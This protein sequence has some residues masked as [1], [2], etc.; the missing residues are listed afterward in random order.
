M[1]ALPRIAPQATVPTLPTIKTSNY[2]VY[3]PRLPSAPDIPKKINPLQPSPP[4]RRTVAWETID[5]H[6]LNEQRV[7]RMKQREHYRYHNS[8]SKYY[9]GSIP[10]KEQY[11][12]STRSVLKQ[13][14]TDLW[15]QNRQQI[16]DKV[17][18]S[19]QAVAYDNS[20]RMQDAVDYQNKFSYLKNFRDDNKNLMESAWQRRR[21]SKFEEDKFDREQLRYNPI[22]WSATL[23]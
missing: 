18:E 14:M 12:A 22:N 3:P 21:Q 16:T 2:E 8:W 23:K 10:E 6:Y 17:Q 20:C 11:R 13:Q 4:Q 15:G 7:N 19:Q 1:S 5:P 9:Y